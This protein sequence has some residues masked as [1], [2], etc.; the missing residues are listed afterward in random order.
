MTVTSVHARRKHVAVLEWLMWCI[1]K[2]AWLTGAARASRA[3]TRWWRHVAHPQ[4]LTLWE[5]RQRNE[6]TVRCTCAG[7]GHHPA[8]GAS[9]L[10]PVLRTVGA[11]KCTRGCS[12]PLRIHRLALR[13]DLAIGDLAVDGP[14]RLRRRASYLI[15]GVLL[16]GDLFVLAVR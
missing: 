6:R 3:L 16:L 1:W 12:L 4:L 13:V 14:R 10:S 2:T 7:I 8:T 11:C 15:V 5:R 9:W